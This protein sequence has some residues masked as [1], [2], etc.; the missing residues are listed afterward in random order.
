VQSGSRFARVEVI[1]E[2]GG[3]AALVFAYAER[4]DA[5]DLDGV[6]SLFDRA[7]WVADGVVTGHGEGHARRQYEPVHIGPDGTPG[8]LHLVSNLI[9]DVAADRSTASAR[10]S[11]VVLQRRGPILA[12]RY[13][14]R[15]AHDAG[16]WYFTERA[17]QADLMGDLSQHFG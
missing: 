15:F 7:D 10:S 9:I 5:G 16:G 6:A 8:T 13:H 17:F 2:E 12:G 1:D 11:F 3:I 4:L 14:D